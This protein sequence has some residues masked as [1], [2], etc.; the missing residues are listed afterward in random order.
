M[1]S[2]LRLEHL[3]EA[4]DLLNQ[5]NRDKEKDSISLYSQFISALVGSLIQFGNNTKKRK[6]IVLQ[7]NRK[8]LEGEMEVENAQPSEKFE[9]LAKKLFKLLIQKAGFD[10][11]L[12]MPILLKHITSHMKLLKPQIEKEVISLLRQNSPC[13]VWILEQFLRIQ[14]AQGNIQGKN[15][16]IAKLAGEGVYELTLALVARHR[17]SKAVVDKGLSVI[18]LF[19]RF[20]KPL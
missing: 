18:I 7:D 6:N 10:Q 17:F 13:G 2:W 14:T 11:Q 5:N 12:F 8:D 9:H 15:E 20:H 19:C 4:L 1:L 3:E 16:L